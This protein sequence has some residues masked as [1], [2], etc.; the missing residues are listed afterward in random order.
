MAWLKPY[1]RPGATGSGICSRWGFLRAEQS[2][3]SRGSDLRRHKVI[4]RWER[5]DS[6]LRFMFEFS[7]HSLVY[8]LL[9]FTFVIRD[10]LAQASNLNWA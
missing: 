4:P 5:M 8:A 7:K 2:S 9:L 3:D 6:P 10:V 1:S